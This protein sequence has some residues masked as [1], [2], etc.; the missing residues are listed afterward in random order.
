MDVP[1][2]SK[3]TQCN[4]H[5]LSPWK[6]SLQRGILT[7]CREYCS[8]GPGSSSISVIMAFVSLSEGIIHRV[9]ICQQKII[10]F[11]SPLYKQLSCIH[12]RLLAFIALLF[13]TLQTPLFR[14]RLHRLVSLKYFF[15][16]F[17]NH[18]S[19]LITR[20]FLTFYFTG[21]AVCIYLPYCRFVFFVSFCFF[22]G[23]FPRTKRNFLSLPSFFRCFS[24][25]I[26][27]FWIFSLSRKKAHFLEISEDGHRIHIYQIDKTVMRRSLANW[28]ENA[29]SCQRKFN[30]DSFFSVGMMLSTA[31]W[32]WMMR[33]MSI[34]TS[35]I[36]TINQQLFKTLKFSIQFRIFS[37]S[38]KWGHFFKILNNVYRIYI[39]R[40]AEQ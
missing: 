6:T 16:F 26:I 31:I 11:E 29:W 40:I 1:E 21:G 4:V 8:F 38:G 9:R 25:S 27:K 22:P 13:K 10:I 3:T 34:S 19:W 33:R 24:F 37:P 2:W 12:A 32:F 35:R 7:V 5:R 30:F 15:F 14:W 23:G 28:F 39:Y 36:D 17:K 18:H 20:T